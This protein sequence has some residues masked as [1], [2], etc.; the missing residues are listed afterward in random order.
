MKEKEQPIWGSEEDQANDILENATPKGFVIKKIDADHEGMQL[1]CSHS[2]C[3]ADAAWFVDG[4]YYCPRHGV[5]AMQ[6]ED[7]EKYDAEKRAAQ[8]TPHGKPND[9][10]SE[11]WKQIN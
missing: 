8:M 3:K 2:N 5:Y 10:E 6:L 7:A 11:P 1:I 4:K 9:E